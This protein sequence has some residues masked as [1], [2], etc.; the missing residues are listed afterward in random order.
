MSKST[1]NQVI[2]NHVYSA[3]V[4][5]H[6]VAELQAKIAELERQQAAQQI[7]VAAPVGSPEISTDASID[8]PAIDVEDTPDDQPTV[9]EERPDT[10]RERGGHHAEIAA[11]QERLA[12]AEA[13]RAEDERER[14]EKLAEEKRKQELE[15][16]ALWTK[17]LEA[18]AAETERLHRTIG[19]PMERWIKLIGHPF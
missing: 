17:A 6:T 10:E 15:A 8:V 9:S 5:P 18:K 11:A 3:P 7:P 14:Q 19:S 13:A 1:N 2:N 16:D 4:D 12:R